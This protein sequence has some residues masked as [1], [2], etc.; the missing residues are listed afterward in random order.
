[1]I[2]GV[3]TLDIILIKTNIITSL[4]SRYEWVPN[5]ECPCSDNNTP[6]MGALYAIGLSRWRMRITG[7]HFKTRILSTLNLRHVYKCNFPSDYHYV[8]QIAYFD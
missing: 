1:M 3:I 5:V 6:I 7:F 4:I 2:V 8:G